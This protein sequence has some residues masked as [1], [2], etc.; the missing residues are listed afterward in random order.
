V[1]AISS[2]Q[3]SFKS[4]QENK[5]GVLIETQYHAPTPVTAP[6]ALAIG[7]QF[8]KIPLTQRQ[9]S[10]N[11]SPLKWC[12]DRAGLDLHLGDVEGAGLLA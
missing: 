4:R 8:F 7:W 6:S 3:V 2:V 1:I 11:R 9:L 12:G 10:P 5:L